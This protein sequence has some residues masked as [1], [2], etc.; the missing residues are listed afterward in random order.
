MKKNTLLIVI[1][2]V[3]CLGPAALSYGQGMNLR[4]DIV[5]SVGEAQESVFILG[6]S[7]VVDGTVKKSVVA[8]GGTVTISGT[9][10]D[11]VV[12]IGAAITLK[13]TA[14][15]KKDVVVIGGSLVRDPGSSVG[16][17]TV[18][19]DLSHLVPG[20]MKGGSR[21]FLS[22]SLV[23][24]ILI[25]K[26]IS[27]FM[28][29]LMAFLVAGVFPKQVALASA[30]VRK[31]FWPIFGTGF[32]G[33]IIFTGLI[34]VSAILSLILIGIP[35]LLFVTVAALVLRVFGQVAL[36]HFF[37]EMLAR[38]FGK[39]N[40]SVLGASLL[41]LLLVSFVGFIP[42]IG[43]LFS[44]V[45]SILAFGAALFTKFGT[46]TN[47]FARKQAPAPPQAPPPPAPPQV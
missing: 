45:M 40:P 24:L 9:V 1:G 6:G 38:S 31:S 27:F 41:G 43:L 33:L 39:H 32:L 26:L 37:G 16:N 15:V 23:P 3:L 36:Y 44:F 13:S 22:L 21:G 34:L 28:W 42:V 12:G 5:V 14:V 18:Y 11:S 17:D 29:L 20:F 30:Q 8:L 4:R 47:W 2:T 7:A 35:I 19:F 25:I 46:T 10:E